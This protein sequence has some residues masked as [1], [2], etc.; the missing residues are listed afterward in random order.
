VVTSEPYTEP[1]LDIEGARAI[2]VRAHSPSHESLSVLYEG[3]RSIVDKRV[4]RPAAIAPFATYKSGT[5]WSKIFKFEIFYLLKA[6]HVPI[7]I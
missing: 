6:A 3:A 7:I 5:G 1:D 4:K 2:Q